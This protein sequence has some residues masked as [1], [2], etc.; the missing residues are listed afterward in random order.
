MRSLS[1]FT[2]LAVEKPEK[3]SYMLTNGGEK[4]KSRCKDNNG[5]ITSSETM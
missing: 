1:R 3:F 2:S 5:K 4:T